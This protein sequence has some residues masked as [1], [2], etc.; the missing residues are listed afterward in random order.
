MMTRSTKSRSLGDTIDVRVTA[1]HCETLHETALHNLEETGVRLP[2]PSAAAALRD[3]GALVREDR[4]RVPRSLVEWAHERAS[5]AVTIC[6][7][8]G[9]PA[10]VLDGT[11]TYYGPGSDCASI[12]DHR[13]SALRAP[14]LGDVRDAVRLV[15]ALPGLDF[16]MSMF[17]P[18]DVDQRTADRHQMRLILTGSDKPVVFVTYKT[19]GCLDAVAMAEHLVGGA[20]R[21]ADGPRFAAT[22]TRRPRCSPTARPWR[23]SSS[24]RSAAY[25]SSTCRGRR[26]A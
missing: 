5:R 24:S 6:D 20:R 14:L 22:S 9:E 2:L 16:V 7:R 15:D 25:R 21:C 18:S 26:R 17:L 1:A 11:R 4:V 13:D 12:L 19:S 3:A 8:R 23:S 10:L